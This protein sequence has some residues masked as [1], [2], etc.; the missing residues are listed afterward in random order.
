MKLPE[1]VNPVA[2]YQQCKAKGIK[3]TSRFPGVYFVIH[4]GNKLTWKA[5]LNHK[6]KNHTIGNFPF[7]IAGEKEADKAIRELQT[8]LGKGPIKKIKPR[9][10]NT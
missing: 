1:G 6:G 9:Q 5:S 2:F 7:T 8:Q 3:I 10:A 4:H